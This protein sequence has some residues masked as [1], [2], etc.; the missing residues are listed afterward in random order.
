[1]SRSTTY[2]PIEDILHKLEIIGNKVWPSNTPHKSASSLIVNGDTFFDGRVNIVGDFTVSG[3]TNIGAIQTDNLALSGGDEAWILRSDENS[4]GKWS[5]PYFKTNDIPLTITGPSDNKVH[6][7]YFIGIGV[8]SPSVP[9]EVSGSVI[10][11]DQFIG[12]YNGSPTDTTIISHKSYKADNDGYA[13]KI[14]NDSQL[15][16]NS[17]VDIN[18]NISDSQ[19]MTIDNFGNIGIGITQPNENLHVGGNVQIDGNLNVEGELT[20]IKSTVLE[21]NDPNIFLARNNPS[22]V[23]DIGVFGQYV[24]NGITKYTGIFRDAS[25][26]NGCISW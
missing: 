4:V 24:D 12:N 22:D 17:K 5:K 19:V 23:M 20:Y 7:E 8:T 1:M 21:V 15:D 26:P 3:S 14:K 25:G 10:L 2:I 16:L 13:I 9:L 6:T 11:G 18:F